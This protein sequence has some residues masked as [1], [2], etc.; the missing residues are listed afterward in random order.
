MSRYDQVAAGLHGITTML[1]LVAVGLELGAHAISKELEHLVIALYLL[2]GLSVLAIAIGRL[3]WRLGHKPHAYQPG[4]TPLA[5][6]T[7]HNV[8][9]ALYVLAVIVPAIGFP[10][11]LLRDSGGDFGIM[12]IASP[13][14]QQPEAYR[15]ITA[16]HEFAAYALIVLAVGHMLALFYHHFVRH[17]ESQQMSFPRRART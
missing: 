15:P 14:V 6:W 11:L 13:L 17:R 5:R 1:I 10:A 4:M 16:L 9:A 2:I 7:I 12:Q 3:A 8:Q